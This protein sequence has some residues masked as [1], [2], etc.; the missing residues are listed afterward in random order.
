MSTDATQGPRR[1]VVA[2][3]ATAPEHIAAG[4][5]SAHGHRHLFHG[6][7]L[8]AGVWRDPSEADMVRSTVAAGASAVSLIVMVLSSLL[9]VSIASPGTLVP[10][11]RPGAFPSWLAGPTGA[12]TSWLNASAH[13]QRVL[14]TTTVAAMLVAYVVVALSAPRLRVAWVLAAVLALHVIFLLSPPLT[15][16]DVFNYLNYGR[17]EAVHHLNPY[18]TIPALEPH[19]DPT[20]ALSNW[21]G[22]LSPYG[23]L[24]TLFTMALVPLGVAGSFWAMK[25]ALMLASLGTVFLVYRCADLLGRNPLRAA[26]IV[27]INPIVLVWG[28]GG[29]HNDFLMIFCLALAFWLLLRA[30]SM[31]V[32]RHARPSPGGQRGPTAAL[33]RGWA[34]LDGM[35]RPLVAGEPAAWME[36]GA[37]IALVAAVAIKASAAVLL[38]VVLAGAARR[39][40]VALG[41]LIGAV[42]AAA[43]TINAFGRE[44][45]EHQPAEPPRGA[46]RHPQPDR[47]RAR[48]R[49]RHLGDAPRAQRR[50]R[51]RGGRGARSGPGARG[52]G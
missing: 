3:P 22:L 43:L 8:P 28:L 38:P 30:D 29:D 23:P 17:M 39:T 35:P 41:L 31:R 21:H 25:A 51:G 26:V 2:P 32:G 11:G 13:T 5:G 15:L 42:A 12:L 46:R 50:P 45:P 44:P 47:A 34:W 18:T 4:N 48:L 10:V 33:R 27:G 16:T 1:F 36:V 24:F 37:G 14:L 40:R 52:A 20:F 49:R 7:V 6:R 9:L 19:S